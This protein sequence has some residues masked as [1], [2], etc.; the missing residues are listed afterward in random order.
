MLSHSVAML[1][2]GHIK[3]LI[4]LQR[5]SEQHCRSIMVFASHQE[6]QDIMKKEFPS[7]KRN[8]MK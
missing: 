1:K 4:K 8:S 7:I 6:K 5:P 3:L 2:S